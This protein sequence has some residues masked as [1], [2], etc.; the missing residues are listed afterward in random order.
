MLRS[1]AATGDD[2]VVQLLL[3]AGADPSGL[4]KQGWFQHER[5]G[6]EGISLAQALAEQLSPD[7]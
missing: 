5:R 7:A 3:E 2:A 4:D 1:A 6:P